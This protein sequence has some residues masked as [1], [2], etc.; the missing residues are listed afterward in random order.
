[1]ARTEKNAAMLMMLH[2]IAEK[3]EENQEESGD[4]DSQLA[5]RPNTS[6]T[7]QAQAASAKPTVRFTASRE[8][9]LTSTVPVETCSDEIVRSDDTRRFTSNDMVG[10]TGNNQDEKLSTMPV[11]TQTVSNKAMRDASVRE[12]KL[13]AETEQSLQD[14]VEEVHTV[15]ASSTSKDDVSG[16]DLEIKVT[17]GRNITYQVGTQSYLLSKSGNVKSAAI[18]KYLIQEADLTKDVIQR[19]EAREDSIKRLRLVAAQSLKVYFENG[20]GTG[21]LVEDDDEPEVVA[22][23]L[24]G[25]SA[26]NARSNQLYNLRFGHIK[27]QMNRA[28]TKAYNELRA[29]MRVVQLATVAVVEALG[30]WARVYRLEEDRQKKFPNLKRNKKR[31]GVTDELNSL[32]GG[33]DRMDDS[34]LNTQ[35]D[36]LSLSKSTTTKSLPDG[37]GSIASAS[38]LSASANASLFSGSGSAPLSTSGSIRSQEEIDP[39]DEEKYPGIPFSG[40][41][42]AARSYCVMIATKGERLYLRSKPI[43]SGMRKYSRGTEEEKT[44]TVVTHV[45]VYKHKDDAINAFELACS[46]VP[47]EQRYSSYVN[48]PKMFIGLRTCR[49]HYLVRTDG[50]S[51]DLPC[52][53]CARMVYRAG[54]SVIPALAPTEEKDELSEATKEAAK[55]SKVE[56]IKTFKPYKPPKFTKVGVPDKV[57]EF[58]PL[59]QFIWHDVNY[60]EKMWED[61][62]FLNENLFVTRF[63]SDTFHPMFNPL[64]LDHDE[65]GKSLVAIDT[66]S[67]EV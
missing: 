39:R 24:A 16:T 43:V 54:S 4:D 12:S 9:H 17:L 51:S 38:M 22:G 32:G 27:R 1:M 3:G 57:S 52:S 66:I 2:A 30:A 37:V 62:N 42:R 34:L 56:K 18:N 36:D 20:A 50:V 25:S 6:A 53:E 49:Q 26:D 7:T 28:E 5:T 64:L 29:A 67:S 15:S 65:L 44:S 46:A 48:V 13:L 21:K 47:L 35:K 58:K 63:V 10:D 33:A 19:I 45:G 55:S 41:S 14:N 11:N 60:L 23:G 59:P 61:C 31:K 40:S 8:L